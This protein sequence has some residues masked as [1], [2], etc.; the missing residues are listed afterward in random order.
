MK[1]TTASR[2]LPVVLGE[3]HGRLT[4]TGE[5]PDRPNRRGIAIRWVMCGCDCGTAKA[6]R[7]SSV[8]G[9]HSA[10][11]GCAT[12]EASTR[13]LM[14][15]CRTHGQSKTA[16][17]HT[18][19]AMV[20]RCT[21]PEHKSW[22]TY[23]GRGIRVC[24]AWLHSFEQFVH[25][26]GCRPP[27]ATLDRIDNRGNYE[28]SNCRWAGVFAQQRNKSNTVFFTRNGVTKTLREWCEELDVRYVTASKRLR[29]GCDPFRPR[30]ERPLAG[31]ARG[32]PSASSLSSTP[33]SQGDCQ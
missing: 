29:E 17:Y 30:T 26:M 22:P 12:R 10:S 4:I 5:L 16:T 14:Q 3:K 18:W 24:E 13:L 7:L 15:R 2:R 31:F 20:S 32:L 27:G 8:R 11:C 25:D 21:K 23:G 9:G 1:R 28:P 6:F 19:A 33:T